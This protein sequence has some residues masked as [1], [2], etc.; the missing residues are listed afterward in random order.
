MLFFT[1]HFIPSRFDGVT[2]GPVSFIRPLF[3]DDFG[4]IAHE[5]T[6]RRQFWRTLGLGC[7]I[8][9]FSQKLRLE[10]E[11]EAYRE[12]LKYDPKGI[13]LFAADLAKN[14]GFGIT[15]S[16]AKLYLK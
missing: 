7:L 12:Q 4:L 8:A 9:L 15:E 14:Y 2:I 16:Q 5:E 1:D 6:H 3:R 13:N 10:Y 11:I